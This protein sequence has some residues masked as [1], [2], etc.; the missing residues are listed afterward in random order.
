MNNADPDYVEHYV[1]FLDVLGFADLTRLA[2]QDPKWRAFLRQSIAT[3]NETMPRQI[4]RTG[5][6]FTQFSDS[7]VMSAAMTIEG[8][9]TVVHGCQLLAHNLLSS[10]IL[11]RGGIA[12]G[13]LHHDDHMLFGPGLIDAYE[14]ERRGG[15]PHIA[16]TEDVARV[17]DPTHLPD[18][19][20]NLVADD[21][22]DL[23]PMLHT[24]AEFELYDGIPRVGGVVLDGQAVHL[25]ALIQHRATDMSS[26]PA[27]RAKWRW[28]QD[29]WNRSIA[30]VGLLARSDARTD[31]SELAQ[32][33]DEGSRQRTEQFNR[34]HPPQ[35]DPIPP[36]RHV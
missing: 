13:R 1:A 3:L 33:A 29:Y 17:L 24:L 2:D 4:E 10:G 26:P 31:W 12:A 23:T 7:I 21:P 36:I 14:F 20:P 27:V 35:T 32:L 22:W 34:D 16:L 19:A 30:T 18:G 11:L 28:Q 25:A 9:S 6:R 8:L 15:P 5:F